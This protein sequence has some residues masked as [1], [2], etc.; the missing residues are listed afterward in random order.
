MSHYGHKNILDEKAEFDT[1]PIFGNMM[2]QTFPLK[3]GDVI[4]FGYLPAEN[5]SNI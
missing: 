1:F 5:W 4:E 2:S 3:N